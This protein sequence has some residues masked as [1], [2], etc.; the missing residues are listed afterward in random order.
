[1]YS[2]GIF[3][4]VLM[5]QRALIDIEKCL[6]KRPYLSCGQ[7]RTASETTCFFFGGGNEF[8]GYYVLFVPA[9]RLSIFVGCHAFSVDG[10][11]L[12]DLY[13]H[14]LPPRRLC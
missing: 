12:N 8:S 5:N 1:M 4:T 6:R 3:H 10:A 2:I 14:T 9:V 7:P 11:L 13:L